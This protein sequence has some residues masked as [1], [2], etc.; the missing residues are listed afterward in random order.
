MFDGLTFPHNG[1]PRPEPR[2]TPTQDARA[3]EPGTGSE[4]YDFY[5]MLPNF[6]VVVPEKE[7]D[8]K[9]DLPTA[10]IERPATWLFP[11]S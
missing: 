5:Q 1:V 10:Q 2:H 4:R 11:F 3:S 6:E 9:R 8:V 7:R